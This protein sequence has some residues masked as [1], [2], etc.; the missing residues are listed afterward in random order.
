MVDLNMA[1]KRQKSASKVWVPPDSAF[2][3]PPRP[4]LQTLPLLPWDYFQ[5]LCARLAQR[6]GDVEFTQ[7]YGLPGQ[8]QEGI[9][10][11]VRRRASSRYTVWQ[12]KKYQ[13]AGASLIR[14]A[15]DEFL[16]GEWA[17]KSDEFVLCIS[18]Q[19]A[20]RSI[21]D[22]IERQRDRLTTKNIT[23]SPLGIVQLSERLKDQPDLV[24][25]FFGLLAVKDFCGEEAA[26]KLAR[27]KLTPEQVGKLRVLLRCCYSHHFESVDP[28]LPSLTSAMTRGPAPLP[29]YERFVMPHVLEPRQF[30][31][32]SI[33]GTP[34]IHFARCGDHWHCCRT[35]CRC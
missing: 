21:A 30:N 12:C 10:I 19:I 22:E 13:E 1:K 5:R 28:G 7:E 33:N 2:L 25:D 8:D 17:V 9:D 6:D 35:N 32:N 26:A 3:L 4:L 27:R 31:A 11:Y 34:T 15:V 20:E 14:D 18:A 23:F 16:A 24:H 29:L